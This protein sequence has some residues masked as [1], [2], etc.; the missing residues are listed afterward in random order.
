MV[1]FEKA[2]YPFAAREG[3]LSHTD[4]MDTLGI[5]GPLYHESQ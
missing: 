1:N 2:N 3:R 5:F 4:L